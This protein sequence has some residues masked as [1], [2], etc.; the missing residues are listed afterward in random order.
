VEQ[1]CESVVGSVTVLGL[2][3]LGRMHSISIIIQL[4]ESM[5]F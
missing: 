5:P 1:G 3:L 4:L 2:I